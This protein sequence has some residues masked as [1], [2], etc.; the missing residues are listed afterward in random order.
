M[1]IDVADFELSIRSI[2]TDNLATEYNRLQKQLN[3]HREV[4]GVELTQFDQGKVQSHF[5]SSKLISL[6]YM[7]NCMNL[8]QVSIA[9]D[10][11]SV[12]TEMIHKG[13][14]H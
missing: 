7:L 11:N 10:L 3:F 9:S 2:M 4:A 5:Y 12:R 1:K 13:N 6:N 14:L 8:N